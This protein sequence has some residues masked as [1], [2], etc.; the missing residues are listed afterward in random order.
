MRSK[1]ADEINGEVKQS[2]QHAAWMLNT[3]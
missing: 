2:I 1:L 3:T